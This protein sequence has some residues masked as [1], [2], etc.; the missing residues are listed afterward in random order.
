LLWYF[1]ANPWGSGLGRLTLL[2]EWKILQDWAGCPWLHG[3]KPLSEIFFARKQDPDLWQADGLPWIIRQYQEKLNERSSL[4]S[5]VIAETAFPM[6]LV[7][8]SKLDGKV[9]MDWFDFAPGRKIPVVGDPKSVAAPAFTARI[10]QELWD[11]MD[12]SR[13]SIQ[14]LSKVFDATRNIGGA[15]SGVGEAAKTA[16]GLGMIIQQAQSSVTFK[17]LYAEETGIKKGLELD[18]ANTQEALTDE[19]VIS[20]TDPPPMLSSLLVNGGMPIGPGDVAGDWHI[21]PVGASESA[22]SDEKVQKLQAWLQAWAQQPQIAG[23]INWLEAARISGRMLDIPELDKI[24]PQDSAQKVAEMM[25]K[26]QQ[27]KELQQ[28]LSTAGADAEVMARRAKALKDASDAHVSIGD[29]QPGDKNLIENGGV[30]A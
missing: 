4:I 19:Q 3:E 9:N 15:S 6:L 26:Q 16:R 12:L 20:V 30:T 13:A 1:E 8:K 23:V 7:D 22:N 18:L 17:L 27:L 29:N 2:S 28:H 25:Q 11:E 10:P 14:R 5:D 21:E 24:L